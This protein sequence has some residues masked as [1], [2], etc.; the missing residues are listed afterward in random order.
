V[1][2]YTVPALDGL[3]EWSTLAQEWPTECGRAWLLA[4]Y[5]RITSEEF[6]TVVSVAGSPVAAAVWLLLTGDEQRHGYGAYDLL[7]GTELD[8]S[9]ERVGKA[10]GP[11]EEVVASLRARLPPGALSPCASVTIAGTTEPAVIWDR[12]LPED[13]LQ[14]AL[15]RLIL[16]IEDAAP[17]R[18]IAFTNVPSDAV[19]QCLRRALELAGYA[20]AAQPAATALQIP[21]DGMDGFISGLTSRQRKSCVREMRVFAQAVENVRA[22]P[23]SRLLDDDIIELVVQRFAKYG[24]GTPRTS[25]IDRLTRAQTLPDLKVLVAERHGRACAFD[26]FV[27]D[28]ERGRMVARI[29]GCEDNDYFAYFNISYYE[30]I[31]YGALHGLT[32]MTLGTESYRAKVLRG[33]V[34]MARQAY[35]RCRDA[36]L[37]VAV[38]E[39]C[40]LRSAVE[41][42]RM[43]ADLESLIP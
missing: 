23:G 21:V 39:A 28:A 32:R 34:V 7:L 6:V 37:A 20:A 12:S 29:S 43:R 19:S 10:R 27:A 16:A 24:H 38:S 9:L 2:S 18:S 31:R 35:V 42:D 26:A 40:A 3:P 13:Q 25:I 33:A 8:A 41:Q 15:A 17:A 14:A 36:G 22:C 30:P 1:R 4:D 11:A 5:G